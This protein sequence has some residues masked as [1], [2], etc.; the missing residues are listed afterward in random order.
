M[1]FDQYP[2]KIPAT[3]NGI[4]KQGKKYLLIDFLIQR[5]DSVAEAQH[6]IIGQ[7]F[8]KVDVVDED[9]DVDFFSF[10]LALKKGHNALDHR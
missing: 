8:I 9:F 6:L 10:N 1:H 4:H 3:F 7:A 2:S 5:D